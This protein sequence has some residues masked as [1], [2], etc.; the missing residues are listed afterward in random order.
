MA[1]SYER[2]NYSLRPAKHIERKMLCEAFRRLSHFAAVESYRYI[3]FGSIYFSDFS[4]VHKSLGVTNMISLERDVENK[5][6]F[7][8]NRPFS[9]IKIKFGASNEILPLLAWKKKTILWLDYDGK[10]DGHVLADVS[11]FCA[12]ASSGSMLVVTI[13]AQPERS[14]E[15]TWRQLIARVG[16]GKV[17]ADVGKG[18]LT[19]WGMANVGRRIITNEIMETI[20][21]RNGDRPLEKRIKYLPVF[22][23][24]Y[25]D[26]AMMMTAGGLIYDERQSEIVARCKFED[27]PFVLQDNAPYTIEVPHLTYRELRH[28]DRQ[29]P[30]D[31]HRRLKAPSIP[32]TDLEK[33]ARLYRHFPTFAEAEL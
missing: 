9:C 3:G 4:L 7:A 28:L 20:N 11:C 2:I 16:E 14:A 6:R 25:R 19:E 31:D 24:H 33:Y 12:N 26:H 15:D 32:D 10:L 29:L 21:Q 17:P 5:R 22:N 27:L 1:S 8:F 13:N 23:F 18:G 30:I